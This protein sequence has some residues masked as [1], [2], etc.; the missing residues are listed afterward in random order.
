MFA[1]RLPTPNPSGWCGKLGMVG[2]RSVG[3]PAFCPRSVSLVQALNL[4]P[5][6]PSQRG[7]PFL[8]LPSNQPHPY[9]VSR[10]CGGAARRTEEALPG[11][12]NIE[13]TRAA[14]LLGEE[15]RDD[16]LGPWVRVELLPSRPKPEDVDVR[17]LWLTTRPQGSRFPSLNL[18]LHLSYGRPFCCLQGSDQNTKST[19]NC[20]VPGT[21]RG[22]Q[23][24][25]LRPLSATTSRIPSSPNTS[26]LGV[27]CRAR[28]S[29][30]E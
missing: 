28:I 4:P 18:F 26:A 17:G 2:R 3:L 27:G 30:G 19:V 8:A 22:Q 1:W 6:P 7:S 14:L 5:V 20:E 15:L 24:C 21:P 12:P 23:L 13:E 11:C 16:E 25:R 10:P 29:W 9:R